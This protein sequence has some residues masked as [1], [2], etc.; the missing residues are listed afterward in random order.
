MSGIVFFNTNTLESIRRFY[1]DLLGCTVW[2]DQGD[3]IILKH[4]NLLLGFC[5]RTKRDLDGLITFF[6]ESKMDVDIMYEMLVETADSP[7]QM[8]ERYG[9]Y[10]FFC[11]D[12]ENRRLE[13]QHFLPSRYPEIVVE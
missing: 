5:T 3:C 9:I 1:V 11:R 13:F 8:N 4:G 12:P 7:P 6:Y 10:H 2:V